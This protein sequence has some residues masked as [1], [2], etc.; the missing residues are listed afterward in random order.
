MHILLRERPSGLDAADAR[1]VDNDP[2]GQWPDF[3]PK[4]CHYPVANIHTLQVI[5]P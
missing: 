3:F 1:C 2:L 4:R 5:A